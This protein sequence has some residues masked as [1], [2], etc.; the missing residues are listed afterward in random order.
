MADGR[1]SVKARLAAKGYQDP[2]IQKG[3][4]DASGRA[5]P[6]S[7]SLQVIALRAIKKWKLRSMGVRNAFSQAGGF[8]RDTRIQAPAE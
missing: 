3:I 6:R 7:P 8:D 4:A 5:S 1:K 2:D